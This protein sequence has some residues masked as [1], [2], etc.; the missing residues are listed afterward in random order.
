MTHKIMWTHPNPETTRMWHFLKF[1]E[2]KYKIQCINFRELHQW[3]CNNLEE[4]WV[5]IVQFFNIKFNTP[6]DNVL[7]N[8]THMTQAHWFEGGKI[9]YAEKLLMHTNLNKTAIISITENNERTNLSYRELLHEVM[10]CRASLLQLGVKEGTR[11]CGVLPNISTSI[12]IFLACAS[13]GAIWSSCSSDFGQQAIIDRLS[14]ITPEVLFITDGHSYLGKTYDNGEKFRDIKVKIPSLQHVILY[15]FVNKEVASSDD[16]TLWQDFLTNNDDIKP[17]FNPL[18]F[19]HP[20]YILFSS[21]TTGKPKCIMHG[22]GGVLLQHLK[23]LGLHANLSAEDNLFFYT[24]TGWMMW[25]WM[26]SAL[27]LNATIILYEGAVQY[28]DFNRLFNIIEQERVTH[29]GTSAKFLSAVEKAGVIPKSDHSFIKLKSILSTGS[30]LL[31]KNFD[32]VY[33]AI[34]KDIQLSSISGGTDIVSCFALGNPLVPVYEGELQSFGLGMDVKVFNEQGK[35]VV[36][37]AGELVCLKPCPSMPIGFWND[38]NNIIYKKAYFEKFKDVWTHGDFAKVVSHETHDGLVIYGRSDT[39]LNPSGI[40]IGT[41]EIYRQLETIPEILDSVVIGQN[42]QDD[43]R[44]VLFLKLK[45]GIELDSAMCE[46]IKTTIRNN[47]TPRH[48]PQKILTVSDIPKTINGK[49]VE[50]AVKQT[51]HNEEI[52]NLGSIANPECLEEFKNRKELQY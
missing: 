8:Y 52:K 28:P 51:V 38:E 23:E 5:S 43:V 18:P 4:F 2:E 47:T 20:L 27:S 11:V 10:Q 13:I 17:E 42:W 32:F 19:N 30:P 16:V 21:G 33:S 29:F 26:V 50:L 49:V 46:K 39:V 35:P 24:T 6:Y 34:K 9:N 7:N 25:N 22:Q 40:R 44:V 48:V 1:I 3:S 15:P 12:I 41:A 45:D 37:Q 31:P 14:Q 36:S